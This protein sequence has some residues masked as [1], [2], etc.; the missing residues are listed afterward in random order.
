VGRSRRGD[1]V[2]M[3]PAA[4]HLQP[5]GQ[6]GGMAGLWG[7]PGPLDARVGPGLGARAP[8][9]GDGL[10]SRA[11]FGQA[12]PLRP[13]RPTGRRPE[14]GLAGPGP[15]GGDAAATQLLDDFTSQR[16]TDRSGSPGSP[17]TFSGSSEKGTSPTAPSGRT[18]GPSGGRCRASTKTVT[19]RRAALPPLA[20]CLSRAERQTVPVGSEPRATRW[21]NSC[22]ANQRRS[23]RA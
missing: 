22:G 14:T 23:A 13:K 6:L 1:S 3:P 20:H 17:A 18:P 2:A 11:K 16:I 5:P 9:P 15:A 21:G 7:Q 12:P 4:H 10:V 8:G 19:R